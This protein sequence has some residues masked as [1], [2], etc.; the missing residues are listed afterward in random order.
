MREQEVFTR[1]TEVVG[2]Q[3]AAKA[4]PVLMK[5]RRLTV[6]TDSSSW[7]QQLSFLKKDL[8]TRF[9]NLLGDDVV[10]DLFFVTGKIEAS[11]TSEDAPPPSCPP[12]SLEFLRALE[13]E[14]SGIPDSELREAFRRL[15]LSAYRRRR[16]P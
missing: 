11:S 15:R 7:T 12:P 3:I 14:S 2:P 16:S 9:A 8:L 4:Q 5:N 6:K 13:E 10:T 1:W